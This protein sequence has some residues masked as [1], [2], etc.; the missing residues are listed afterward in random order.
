MG[1]VSAVSGEH[2]FR[3]RPGFKQVSPRFRMVSVGFAR[4]VSVLSSTGKWRGQ[5]AHD[6]S[7]SQTTRPATTSSR[8]YL[9][10]NARELSG[11]LALSIRPRRTHSSFQASELAV[12]RPPMPLGPSVST[13]LR[14]SRNLAAHGSRAASGNAGSRVS[15]QLFA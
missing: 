7:P 1:T 11:L 3:F 9:E 13:L 4:A 8:R 5:R 10:N 6:K 2:S 15:Q 14:A 12:G